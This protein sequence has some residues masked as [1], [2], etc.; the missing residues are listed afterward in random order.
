MRCT[1]QIKNTKLGL[2]FSDISFF[3]IFWPYLPLLYRQWSVF[4]GLFSCF[5]R[6]LHV[7]KRKPMGLFEENGHQA[8]KVVKKPLIATAYQSKTSQRDKHRLV[9]AHTASSWG[10]DWKF[11]GDIKRLQVCLQPKLNMLSY[12]DKW[13]LTVGAGGIMCLLRTP[14]VHKQRLCFMI[15]RWTTHITWT[16]WWWC[17]DGL[18]DIP[19]LCLIMEETSPQHTNKK[20]SPCREWVVVVDWVKWG[21]SALKPGF[22]LKWNLFLCCQLNWLT[23]QVFSYLFQLGEV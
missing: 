3:A 15:E 16:R 5:T 2:Q 8:K 22:V 1:L 12:I 7:K 19:V 13:N 21:L 10:C 4:F 20:L 14:D 23:I 18:S 11:S 6:L 17:H 9:S